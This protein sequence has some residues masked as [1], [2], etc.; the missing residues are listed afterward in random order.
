MKA[1]SLKELLELD[2]IEVVVDPYE[3]EAFGYVE[4]P[5][6]CS[7]CGAPPGEICDCASNDALPDHEHPPV[8]H[9]TPVAATGTCPASYLEDRM[10]EAT[11]DDVKGNS[12]TRDEAA[13]WLAQWDI[14]NYGSTVEKAKKFAKRQLDMVAG[15]ELEF[16]NVPWAKEGFVLA[17]ADKVFDPYGDAPDGWTDREEYLA[18]PEGPGPLDPPLGESKVTDFDKYMDK[19]LISEGHGRPAVPPEDNPQRRRAAK[20]QDRPGNKTRFGAK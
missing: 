18:G 17:T 1:K 19:I 11:G 20:H 6:E 7:G 5:P 3:E 4:N 12:V 15:S 16:L 13:N 14:D 9:E 2:P 10:L 8:G